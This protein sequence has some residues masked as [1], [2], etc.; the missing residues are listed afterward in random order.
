MAPSA[1]IRIG[2]GH[3]TTKHASWRP[4]GTVESTKLKLYESDLPMK[5][6]K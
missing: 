1:A 4:N 6:N 3:G 2:T 5:A